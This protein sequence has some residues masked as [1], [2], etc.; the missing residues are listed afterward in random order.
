V[1]KQKGTAEAV[2]SCCSG[3]NGLVFRGA[4]QV[5]VRVIFT[6]R[7][8]RPTNSRMSGENDFTNSTGWCSGS[9]SQVLQN[10]AKVFCSAIG[11]FIFSRTDATTEREEMSQR[12]RFGGCYR[13]G[14]SQSSSG[15]PFASARWSSGG[16]ENSLRTRRLPLPRSSPRRS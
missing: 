10:S 11:S 1:I 6:G 5:L 12:G 15:S 3:C 13:Q 16:G 2:P 14:I 9:A 8:V 4:T 7:L